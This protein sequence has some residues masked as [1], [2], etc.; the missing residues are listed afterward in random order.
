MMAA[1]SRPPLLPARQGSVLL[2][3]VT[4]SLK[5][6][7]YSLTSLKKIQKLPGRALKNLLFCLPVCSSVYL[8]FHQSFLVATPFRW[9]RNKYGKASG[10]ALV[11]LM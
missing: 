8:F 5:N 6:L 7:F 2:G 4:L 11:M 9:P 1:L 10:T 3:A